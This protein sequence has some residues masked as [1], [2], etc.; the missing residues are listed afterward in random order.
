MELL[1][2]RTAIV[3]GPSGKGYSIKLEMGWTGVF[4]A[5]GWS[6]FLKF[7]DI[8]EANALLL[9]YE[10]NMVFTLKAY[11]PNGY[12]REFNQRKTEVDKYQHCQILK[13]SRKHHLLPFRSS[14]KHHLLPFR[15][16]ITTICQAVM[17]KRNN[18][19]SQHLGTRHHSRSRHHHR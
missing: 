10:G 7:H 19:A 2:N 1:D 14:K 17:E 3:F 18:K 4:F 11:G 8:T 12:Q 9:R 6:Q 15:S 5:V 16:S 13:S